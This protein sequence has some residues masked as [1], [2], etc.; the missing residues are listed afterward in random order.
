MKASVRVNSLTLGGA[1]PKTLPSMEAHGKRLDK[2]SQLRRV[3]DAEPLVYGS[4]DLRRA[5]D[6]HVSGCR[7]NAALKRPVLHAV[8]QF[9]PQ[10]GKSEKNRKAMLHHAVRFIEKTHGGEAVFA[11]R[12]DQ[13]EAGM[14]TV[15]VFYAPK[16][17][18]VT[19]KCAET[20][21]STTKHGKELA[22]KHRPEIERRHSGKF[23]AGPRQVGIA[24][25]SEL[26]E[27]LA[28]TG[29]KLEPKNEKRASRP[30]RVDPEVFKARKDAEATL[31]AAKAESVR[32]VAE[33]HQRASEIVEEADQRLS[34]VVARE[35]RLRGLLDRLKGLLDRVGRR[36]GLTIAT[37]LRESFQQLRTELDEPIAIS[38]P[39]CGQASTPKKSVK[40]SRS[41][42]G[43][44]F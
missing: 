7:M 34:V 20:W 25:Q 3:R 40:P 4:L 1:G 44:G 12:L 9:P 42:D 37:T 32:V 41:L 36:L 38:D 8:V 35:D 23:S 28:A 18:K 19:K 11:A 29:L 22:Q 31:G 10:A 17:Q 13:D 21:V 16:Y 26:H 6:A 27:Y 39:F 24:L 2:T 5:Y 30:D 14:A 33:A 15:D 43:L